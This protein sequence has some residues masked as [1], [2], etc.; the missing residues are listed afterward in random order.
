MTESS[1]VGVCGSCG[2]QTEQRMS[3]R[4]RHP[5]DR[6]RVIPRLAWQ[7]LLAAWLLSISVPAMAQYPLLWYGR[8]NHQPSGAASIVADGANGAVCYNWS[9][10]VSG[11]IIGATRYLDEASTVNMPVIMQIPQGW[12]RSGDGNSIQQFVAGVNDHPALSGWYIYDEPD[13]T[14][15]SVEEGIIAYEAIKSESA[16]PIYGAINANRADVQIQYKD[17]YDIMLGFRYPF[18]TGSEEFEGLE[19]DELPPEVPG[20]PALLPGWKDQVEET[21]QAAI[22]NGKGFV[23]ILQATGKAHFTTR[24]PTEAEF[25]FMVFYS[26]VVHDVDGL[27]FWARHHIDTSP[28][29]ASGPYKEDGITWRQQ[30]FI[31]MMD[32]FASYG[33]AVD[34]GPVAGAVISSNPIVKAQ[35]YHDAAEDRD[36]LLAVNE[37]GVA[38]SAELQL[39][40]LYTY[41][42]ARILKT[43]EEYDI[44]GGRIQYDF[45]R[46]DTVSFELIRRPVNGATQGEAYGLNVDYGA[47]QVPKHPLVQLSGE[48]GSEQDSAESAGVGTVASVDALEVSTMGELGGNKGFVHSM[49]TSGAVSL[50]NGLI[51]ADSGIASSSSTVLDPCQQNGQFLA[52]EGYAALSNLQIAGHSYGDLEPAPN[53]VIEVPG[54]ARI[55]LNEQLPGGDNITFSS[56]RV[57]LMRVEIL[58]PIDPSQVDGEIIVSSA[59]SALQFDPSAIEF[60]GYAVGGGWLRQNCY[61]A[62]FGFIA[63][64]TSDGGYNGGLIF[65][66]QA[67]RTRVFSRSVTSFVGHYNLYTV[68]V[69]GT[70]SLDGQPGFTYRLLAADEAQP[71]SG[72]DRFELTVYDA[73]GNECYSSIGNYG[74]IIDCGN[75]RVHC[76]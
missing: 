39:S 16:A 52:S 46:Y 43:G 35:V 32:E 50:L 76:D 34:A 21:K 38:A 2:S 27:S 17:S 5:K 15:T 74:S 49:A 20:G 9:G 8:V 47:V 69:T 33:D 36:F 12:V 10:T 18:H 55:T 63:G 73:D 24:L 51:T 41:N 71:G 31:P 66:D 48:G 26:I 42:R 62:C 13:E 22:L 60:D 3:E 65:Y 75:V 6:Q 23:N 64:T 44:I 58:N 28:A 30:I 25:R 56:L 61:R 57:H 40:Q 70:C 37:E 67:N 59:Y 1:G 53:H 4:T 45:D 11:A 14:G 7:M 72:V 29:D 19:F 68:L 54:V